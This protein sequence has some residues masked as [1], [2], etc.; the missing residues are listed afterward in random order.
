MLLVLYIT[1]FPYYHS[2]SLFDFRLS[3]FHW[4][5]AGHLSRIV[6]IMFAWKFYLNVITERQR[7]TER[8]HAEESNS[9]AE[10]YCCLWLCSP[11]KKKKIDEVSHGNVE[12]LN[13]K[14]TSKK[15][16]VILIDVNLYDHHEI[17]CI[18]A[19]VVVMNSSNIE[20]KQI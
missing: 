8:K 15:L 9:A 1:N 12:K 2:F 16:N 10:I 11:K 19:I 4:V 17:Y 6:H 20:S 5:F 18:I 13:M 14:S 7:K 3:Q